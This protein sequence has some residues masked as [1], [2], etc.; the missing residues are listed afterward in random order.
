MGCLLDDLPRFSNRLTA[1]AEVIAARHLS[2]GSKCL[3]RPSL[4]SCSTE[5]SCV[6]SHLKVSRGVNNYFTGKHVSGERLTGCCSAS[7]AVSRFE[8]SG[9]RSSKMKFFADEI[10]SKVTIS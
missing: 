9:L 3:R 1:F 7:A 4:R 5:G 2:R 6:V 8:E 10:G